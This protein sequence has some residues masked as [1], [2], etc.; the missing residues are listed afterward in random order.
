VR[1]RGKVGERKERRGRPSRG[2]RE[3]KL[4][5][6]LAIEEMKGKKNEC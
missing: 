4:E 6:E 1:E 3:K 5:R 2:T